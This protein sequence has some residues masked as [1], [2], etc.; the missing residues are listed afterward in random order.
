[1]KAIK[2]VSLLFLMFFAINLAAPVMSMGQCA[3]CK[4]NAEHSA[5]SKGRK[6]GLGLNDG[7]LLLLSMPYAI[8]GVVGF[9]WYKRSRQQ[10][11]N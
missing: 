6:Q 10:K 4:L 2:K 3:M 9:M 11:D 1:M 5:E 7:I 8:V